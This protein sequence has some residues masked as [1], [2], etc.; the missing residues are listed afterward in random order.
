MELKFPISTNLITFC[1][2]PLPITEDL[3][4]VLS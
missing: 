3:L 1:V 2:S 4:A